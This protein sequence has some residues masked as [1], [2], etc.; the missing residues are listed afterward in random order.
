VTFEKGDVM[1]KFHVGATVQVA[2]KCE[3]SFEPI[4]D[5]DIWFDIRDCYHKPNT[6]RRVFRDDTS[7]WVTNRHGFGRRILNTDLL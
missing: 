5:K 2:G 4:K 3:C 1:S 7:A 6:V